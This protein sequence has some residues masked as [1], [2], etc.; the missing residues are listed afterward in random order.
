ME[1]QYYEPPRAEAACETP[2]PE[3]RVYSPLQRSC[4]F[5]P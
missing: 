2:A 1:Q 4:F 5:A 3:K